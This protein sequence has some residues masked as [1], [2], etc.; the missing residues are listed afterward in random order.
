[1]TIFFIQRG[2]NIYV[3]ATYFQQNNTQFKYN[4]SSTEHDDMNINN[5]S[6]YI[7]RHTCQII[8]MILPCIALSYK[9]EFPFPTKQYKVNQ[10]SDKQ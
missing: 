1:M 7:F 5:T 2:N 4:S 6:H 3:M 9:I 8:V 10:I